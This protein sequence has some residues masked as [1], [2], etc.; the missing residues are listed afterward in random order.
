MV[1]SGLPFLFFF[2]PLTL[3]A[4]FLAP[5]KLKKVV[6]FVAS[7]IFY[8]WGEPVYVILMLGSIAV[9]YA[10]ALFIKTP[11]GNRKLPMIIAIVFDLAML[12]VF[13]YA[14]LVAATITDITGIYIKKPDL[15]LPIGISFYTFQ[16]MSYVIDV[17]RDDVSATKNPIDFGA[18]LTMFPQL[19]AGPIVRY[20]TIEQELKSPAI[21]VENFSEGITRFVVGL[22]KKVLIANSIGR[23][24]DEISGASASDLSTATAW[25]GI[26]AFTLQIYFDFSGYSDMA[27]GMG[28]ML[29]FHFLENFDHPYES[30]S[31]TEFWR[32]WHIS[33]STWFREYVYYPLG[34]S[35]RG[36]GR[37]LFNIFIVWM[38]TGLW[39]GATKNFVIWGIYYAVLLFI[40]KLCLYPILQKSP[41]PLSAIYTMFFVAIGWAIFSWQDIS[42]T[43]SF[44]GAMA[45]FAPRG[46]VDPSTLYFL[47][48]YAILFII[49][50]S[51]S[52]TV[53]MRVWEKMTGGKKA[54]LIVLEAFVFILSVAA[55]VSDTYNPFLYFRF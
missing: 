11:D 22:G 54:P 21:S 53:P 50:I 38:L 24:W 41:K 20:K 27:I 3:A 9:N 45:F 39:H 14:G 26:A 44:I 37:Q 40:E 13:K 33:L 32:R 15:A 48:S 10:A 17:Y 34:G 2:L 4:Y 35:R 46:I 55:L 19:I 47:K 8:A 23:V 28:R 25:I 51:G 42:D 49:A 29:G 18:Y 36:Q 43:K 31:I 52:T 16:A 12:L 30:K 5:L 7:I 1:F 6:L